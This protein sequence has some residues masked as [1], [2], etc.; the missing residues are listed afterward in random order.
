MSIELPFLKAICWQTADIKQLTPAE[1]LSRYEQG[2]QYRGV[3]GQPSA[4]ELLWIA[5]ISHCYGSWLAAEVKTKYPKLKK[6]PRGAT[7]PGMMQRDIHKKILIILSNLKA[8]FFFECGAFFGGG[9]LISLQHGEYRESKDIDFLCPVGAG[10]RLLRQEVARV[11]YDALFKSQ[12]DITLRGDI[13][14]N[15]YGIRFPV[16]IDDTI[17]KFEIVCEGRISFGKPIYHPWSVVP[18]LNQIDSCAEKLL[19]NADRWN[20]T[21]VESRDL[22]DLAIQRIA[23]PLPPAAIDKAES[24]YPVIEPLHKAIRYFHSHPEFRD[25]CFRSLQV[26]TP[27]II[28]Q[29]LYLLAADLAVELV[30]NQQ[31]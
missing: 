19:A 1:M 16:A 27:E 13:R 12:K 17:I 26:Q 21:S 11:G 10:Y 31:D 8:E 20:D 2:W 9:T 29:G 28:I 15:Q 24:A 30:P 25:K 3:L 22:I 23:A 4:E 7:I 6:L 5:E 18:C 14:A